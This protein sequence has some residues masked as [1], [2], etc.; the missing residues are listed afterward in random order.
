MSYPC[1]MEQVSPDSAEGRM[2]L[3]AYFR[4]IMRRHYA[5]DVTR[6]EVDAA[7]KVEPS[8][9]LRPPGGAFFVARHGGA[10]VGCAGLRL[11]TA[12]IGEVTRVFVRPEARR[13]GVGQHLMEAVEDAARGQR[14]T[15]LRLDTGSHLPEARQLYLKNGYREVPAFNQGRL[16]DQWYEKTLG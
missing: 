5:R 16:S 15:R 1:E 2:V 3:E 4:D 6:D 14:V 7:M 8:S 13:R 12:G 11:I 10:V 9:D